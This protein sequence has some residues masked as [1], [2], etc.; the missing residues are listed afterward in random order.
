MAGPVVL[1]A[2]GQVR[3]NR[4]VLDLVLRARDD[5]HPGLAEPLDGGKQDH[6]VDAD[7]IRLDAGQD[8][9]KILLGPLRAVDDRFPAFLDVVVDLVD[10]RLAEIRDVAVD[11]VF[12]EL[13]H[14]LRRHGLG[15]VHRVGHESVALVDLDEAGV[16]QEDRP[17]SPRL[18]GLGDA[19]GVQR[20]PESGLGKECECLLWHGRLPISSSIRRASVRAGRYGRETAHA[21]RVR[22]AP[23]RDRSDA[24]QVDSVAS[25]PAGA[26]SEA[27][28]SANG[29][30]V[31][32]CPG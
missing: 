14:L 30:S 20:G 5:S 2:A 26:T 9:R 7:H 19:H 32:D 16:G 27:K 8:A 22:R 21:G 17:V 15:E 1:A 28:G 11:E 3:G 24:T 4:L 18:E 13:R 23:G 31:P 6:V 10:R 29:F 25:R 12:P